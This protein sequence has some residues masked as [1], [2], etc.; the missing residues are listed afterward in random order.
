MNIK[1]KKFK[2]KMDA[3]ELAALFRDIADQLEGSE[4]INNHTLSDAFI[5]FN[6][7]S[8]KLKRK[9]DSLSV[10]VKV[11]TQPQLDETSPTGARPAAEAIAR[12]KT[13][14]VPMPSYTSDKM[15]KPKYK[16]LKKRMKSSFKMIREALESDH[17]PMAPILESF[18]RDSELMV[19][20]PGYGDEYYEAYRN[21][22][23]HFS[24][25]C[26][27]GDLGALKSLTIELNRMKSDCHKRYK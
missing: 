12:P 14:K 22:C 18:I 27:R 6:K 5:D 8:L 7:A 1:E 3:A 11:E 2:K 26:N 15:E 20:Y 24:E 16:T 17:M 9:S 4:K 21:L 13:D 10:K 19:S 23:S 25:A